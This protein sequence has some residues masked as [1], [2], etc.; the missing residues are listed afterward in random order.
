MGEKQA[1]SVEK[2][3]EKST[4][5]VVDQVNSL[6]LGFEAAAAMEEGDAMKQFYD[7][8]QSFVVSVFGQSLNSFLIQLF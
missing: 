6:R 1:K 5:K 8:I 2:L 3:K 4:T 7:I